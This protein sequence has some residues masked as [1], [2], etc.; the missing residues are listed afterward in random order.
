MQVAF[1]KTENT[2]S[3]SIEIYKTNEKTK[4]KFILKIE[5]EFLLFRALSLMVYVILQTK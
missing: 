2:F 1:K 3:N 4:T 5:I